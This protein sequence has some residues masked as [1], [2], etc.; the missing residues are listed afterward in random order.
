MDNADPQ[1]KA[2]SKGIQAELNAS[3]DRV[4][5]LLEGKVRGSF[6]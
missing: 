2:K 1:K 3:R 4:R 5:L 6:T